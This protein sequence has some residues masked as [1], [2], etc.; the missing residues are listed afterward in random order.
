MPKS[1]SR[2]GEDIP[3]FERAAGLWGPFAAWCLKVSNR[4]RFDGVSLPSMRANDRIASD[5]QG[6]QIDDKTLA[7]ICS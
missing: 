6:R 4:A 3:R 2:S 1:P 7:G 5:Q